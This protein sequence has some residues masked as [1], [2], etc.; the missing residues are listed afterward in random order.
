VDKS[1][2]KKSLHQ[3]QQNVL[4]TSVAFDK[5]ASVPS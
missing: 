2:F 1:T 4:L 3:R 5:E